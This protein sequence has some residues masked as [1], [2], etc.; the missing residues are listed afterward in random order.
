MTNLQIDFTSLNN[1]LLCR[2]DSLLPAWLPCGRREGQEYIALNPTRHDTTLGSFRINLVTGQWQDFATGDKGGDIVSLYAYLN[3]VSQYQAAM[4][5]LGNDKNVIPFAPKAPKPPKVNAKPI[6]DYLDKIWRGCAGDNSIVLAY[7]KSRGITGDIPAT[8]KQYSNLYHKPSGLY[9]PAMV[10]AVSVW[11]DKTITALHRTYIKNDSSG[12]ADISPNK[13]MLG[14]TKGGAVRLA[15]PGKKL[16]IAEGVE[17]ALSIQISTGLPTWAA[18]ST[19][20]L[21]NVKVP[22]LDITHEILIAADGDSA[23][24]T[25]ANKLA[26]RLLE[27]GYKVSIATPSTG[28][29]FNDVL[30][31]AAQ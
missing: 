14:K 28:M 21:L 11:P 17:T 9:Y 1:S 30:R 23:G 7:L 16:A 22:P 26:T 31:G 5:L 25:A 13:M 4:E 18:L 12:K 19:S 2:V 29:D 10:A 8:I 15:A 6:S 20:G 3:G 27:G 24:I